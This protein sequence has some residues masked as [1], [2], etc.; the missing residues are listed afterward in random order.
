[1][2]ICNN[3]PPTHASPVLI[4]DHLP[5][6]LLLPLLLLQHLPP[7]HRLVPPD[8]LPRGLLLVQLLTTALVQDAELK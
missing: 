5:P 3:R 6:P 4:Y 2:Q 1:M 8:L 7:L